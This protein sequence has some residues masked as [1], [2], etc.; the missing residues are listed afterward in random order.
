MRVF[1][2]TLMLE[3]EITDVNMYTNKS[4]KKWNFN[5]NDIII[6]SNFVHAKYNLF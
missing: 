1:F 4:L 2:L 3:H 5:D 6:N